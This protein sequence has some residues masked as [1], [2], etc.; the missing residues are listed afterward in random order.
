MQ[1]RWGA[2]LWFSLARLKPL[3]CLSPGE[4]KN[5]KAIFIAVGVVC[6]LLV[7]LLM[8]AL[9]LLRVRQKKGGCLPCR[10]PGSL[11]RAVLSNGGGRR[12][13][14]GTAYGQFLPGMR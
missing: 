4:G 11:P 13:A 14:L 6:A 9:Y 7:A 3:S 12:R 10:F 8:A 5:S 2:L 1:R